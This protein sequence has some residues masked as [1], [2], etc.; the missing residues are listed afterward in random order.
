[1]ANRMQPDCTLDRAIIEPGYTR[2]GTNHP[3]WCFCPSMRFYID[4]WCRSF[5]L[6]KHVKVYRLARI[7]C[8]ILSF[9]SADAASILVARIVD[10]G[11]DGN[12]FESVIVRWR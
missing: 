4:Q 8:G 2:R 1:M 7:T 3:N 6:V 5:R 12:Q 9:A 10:V 11:R